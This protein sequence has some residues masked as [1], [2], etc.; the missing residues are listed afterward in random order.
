[1]S[2]KKKTSAK[3]TK[4]NLQ[5][6]S[7]KPA[8][9]AAASKKGTPKTSADLD[10]SSKS[11]QMQPEQAKGKKLDQG[12]AKSSR[13]ES[14]KAKTES[15]AK[16]APSSSKPQQSSPKQAAPKTAPDQPKQQ[17]R[18][19]GQQPVELKKQEK[20]KPSPVGQK[21]GKG[22]KKKAVRQSA[23]SSSPRIETAV[24]EVDQN[25]LVSAS[26]SISEESFPPEAK[27][28]V[29]KTLIEEESEFS[30]DRQGSE[31]DSTSALQPTSVAPGPT[32][33][34]VPSSADAPRKVAKTVLE[35][36]IGGLK[37]A[38]AKATGL[39][40]KTPAPPPAE[41]KVA[42][43]LMDVSTDGLRDAVEASSRAIEDEIAA[44]IRESDASSE[45]HRDAVEVSARA[46]ED[47]IAAA[48]REPE[49][50][51]GA[52][53]TQASEPA[54]TDQ[55]VAHAAKHPDV[56]QADRKIAKTMLDFRTDELFELANS[57]IDTL[58]EE[59][60]LQSPSTQAAPPAST[61]PEPT[62]AL[63][64]KVAKT[65]LE[66]DVPDV[67]AIVEAAQAAGQE[68]AAQAPSVQSTAEQSTAE[69]A[70]VAQARHSP[71][72]EVSMEDL[73]EFAQA[74][75]EDKP[76]SARAERLRKTMLGI[77]K[78]GL[79]SSVSMPGVEMTGETKHQE[80]GAQDA[81]VRVSRSLHPLDNFSFDNLCPADDDTKADSPGD[82]QP[83][84]HDV[85]Q[86][87]SQSDAQAE[88]VSPGTVELDHD[89]H[90]AP[91]AGEFKGV[92]TVWPHEKQQ[93]DELP[94]QQDE[95]RT[96]TAKPERF[97]PKTMLDM[98]FLKESLSASVVRAEEKLAESIALKAS[99]PPKQTLTGDDYKLAHPNCPFVWG[100]DSGKE[101][102]KYC[103]QCS[104]QVY[105]FTGFDMAEAQALIF[106]RENRENAPLY[107][108]EDG[109]FMTSDCP[110]AVKKQKDRTM[111]IGGAA[112][113]LI[114]L[115]V[116]VVASF[117]APQPPPPTAPTTVESKSKKTPATGD[118]AL[119]EEAPS[120]TTGVPT[121][122]SSGAYH[123]IR[124]K[125]VVKNE[126]IIVQPQPQ[127][128]DDTTVPGT[129]SG[130]DEGGQFWQYTDKG[131]N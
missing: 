75:R 130:Y 22:G 118:K 84:A 3:Q 63:P 87:E 2:K 30:P 49:A 56:K 7:A 92:S 86:V 27:R 41:R 15:S 109:K 39:E 112:L 81:P 102:V 70:P 73:N 19:A 99:A 115:V 111:L 105:N 124:G 33:A 36:N 125:G 108:R 113:A 85:A 44:A 62:A 77:R 40:N 97:V 34:N 17:K 4:P 126:P 43:T 98:D 83:D 6:P 100:D 42:K 122:G 76:M 117:L 16:L 18:E 106:K 64:R 101:R 11:V 94:Q 68:P 47:E 23:E 38:A 69:Q 53:Q 46:I 26:A 5:K 89:P 14:S 74:L 24:A 31:G 28:K 10:V 110:I 82:S 80:M 59:D 119:T 13:P 79:A 131:N 93:R 37:E 107:K 104:A 54:S 48:I 88:S 91:A 1:M 78:H 45:G 25:E 20:A 57:D 55:V 35:V 67:N 95:A 120:T 50:E 61:I 8:K 123:Y 116:M 72:D 9:V 114:L 32:P 65:M 58:V 51:A 128:P 66:L 129:T 127:Q 96:G 29:P 12:A 60:V 52:D 71:Y 21:A 121:K 103:T 90:E